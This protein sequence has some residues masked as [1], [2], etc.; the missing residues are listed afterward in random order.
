MMYANCNLKH[1]IILIFNFQFT[2]YKK[3]YLLSANTSGTPS[4]NSVQTK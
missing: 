1:K 2:D 3:L 4:E